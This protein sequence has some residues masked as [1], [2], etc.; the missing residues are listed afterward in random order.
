MCHDTCKC[1][2]WVGGKIVRVGDWGEVGREDGGAAIAIAPRRERRHRLVTG[3]HQTVFQFTPR[4]GSDSSRILAS[5]KSTD[6]NPRSREGSDAVV[7]V[8]LDFGE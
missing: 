6:F 7:L 2:G 1:F 8:F 3:L 5:K 4:E